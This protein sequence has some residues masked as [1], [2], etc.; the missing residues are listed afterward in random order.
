[1]NKKNA[2]E[3]DPSWASYAGRLSWAM[4]RAGKPNQS[5]LARAVGVKPQ[6][7]QYLCDPHGGAQGSS[8]T[9]SLAR[10]LGVSAEWLATGQGSP[11]ALPPRGPA[12]LGA[13]NTK[14]DAPGYAVQS[15]GPAAVPIHRAVRV[16]A[17]GDIEALDQ[18]DGAGASTLRLPVFTPSQGAKALRIKGHALSP[19]ARDGQFLVTEEMAGPLAPQDLL[20]LSLLDGRQVIRELMA[21]RPDSLLVLPVLGGQAQAIDRQDIARI[22]LVVCVLPR[23]Y[24]S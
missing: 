22:E 7:I 15:H 8:H 18:A 24:A 3:S 16:S 9:P 5:E 19:W 4:R 10:E 23:R 2:P 17:Q 13:L 1:M 14:E 6:S 11:L 12:Q 21:E 20:L